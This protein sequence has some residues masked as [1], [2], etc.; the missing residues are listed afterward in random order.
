MG[1]DEDRA[2][3]GRVVAP[4]SPP[5]LITPVAANRAEHVSTHDRRAEILSPMLGPIVVESR[6][7]VLRVCAHRLE[8][9]RSNHPVVQL[10]S[11][12]AQRVAVSLRGP[13]S[14]C[15]LAIRLLRF[16]PNLRA[17]G[18]SSGQLGYETPSSISRP[19]TVDPSL[20]Q[21]APS[22]LTVLP[23]GDRIAERD[24][25][26]PARACAAAHRPNHS[27][28]ADHSLPA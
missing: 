14:P 12:F 3:I 10:L 20:R 18:N 15:R 7:A 16:R 17:R 6:L 24:G 28:R 22:P 2:V 19:R 21:Q 11:A 26:C 13:S 25:R 23:Q 1:Q 5:L 8:R 9:P 27:E 4:P